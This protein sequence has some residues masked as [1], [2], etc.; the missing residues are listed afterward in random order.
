MYNMD[1]KSF[2][3]GSVILSNNNEE[4][5][6]GLDNPDPE[7]F[8]RSKSR[9]EIKEEI[10]AEKKAARQA[11]LA[12][13]RR[14]REEKKN[15]PKEKRPDLW[16]LGGLLAAII[17]GA[18]IAMAVQF[19]NDAKQALYQQDT[20]RVSYFIDEEATPEL[21]DDGITAAVN[22]AYYTVGGHLCVQMTLGNGLDEEQHMQALEVQIYDGKEQLIGGGYTENIDED[23][24]IPANGT[25]TYTFYI[26]PEHVKN[27]DHLLD[28]ISY[29][30]TATGYTVEK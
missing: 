2:T 1:G 18:G 9:D 26:S 19:S 27:K 24:V 23:Y 22:K 21:E 6:I 30:I 13:M 8:G 28:S 20:E 15:A 10:K 12:E 11:Q 3:R 25:N 4:K 5:I 14:L 16:V 29:S 17:I 7:I